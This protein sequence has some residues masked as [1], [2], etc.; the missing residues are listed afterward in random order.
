MMSKNDLWKKTEKIFEKIRPYMTVIPKQSVRV[1]Q[2]QVQV[3]VI[4]G[5]N[6]WKQLSIV[7]NW[8]LFIF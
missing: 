7:I 5:E 8:L 6:F 2:V 1:V 3:Q 4:S